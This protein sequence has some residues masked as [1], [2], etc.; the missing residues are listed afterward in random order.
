M[1]FCVLARYLGAKF[2]A[3]VI[4]RRWLSHATASL[5]RARDAGCVIRRQF[6]SVPQMPA[7]N[8]ISCRLHSFLAGRLSNI[9]VVYLF[10]VCATVK[11]TGGLAAKR[12]DPTL[13]RLRTY[14]RG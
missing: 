6:A 1:A 13:S 10:R 2:V 12:R 9:V 4:E 14:M 8:D 7:G 3:V 11:A 5:S